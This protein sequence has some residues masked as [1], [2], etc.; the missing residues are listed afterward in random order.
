MELMVLGSRALCEYLPIPSTL[1]LPQAVWGRWKGL[2]SG[3]CQQ[4]V[5]AAVPHPGA[6]L[7]SLVP[8]GSRGWPVGTQVIGIGV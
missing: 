1:S 2:A 4:A 3:L 8:L 6:V 5:I 7:S